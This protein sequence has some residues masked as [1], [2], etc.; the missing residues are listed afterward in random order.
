MAM[1]NRQNRRDK[2]PPEVPLH[3]KSAIQNHNERNVRDFGKF[4]A[5]RQIRVGSASQRPVTVFE[6]QAERTEAS[7]K[8]V[9]ARALESN[10]QK[11]MK[12]P[13]SMSRITSKRSPRHATIRKD[14]RHSHMEMAR[15][16][17][18]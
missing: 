5:V 4:G 6:K 8:P 15:F 12:N 9:A 14:F 11:K 16:G 7:Q 2:L 10:V 18:E 17:I 13:Q 3:Q 1:A